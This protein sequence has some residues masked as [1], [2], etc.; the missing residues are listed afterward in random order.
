MGTKCDAEGHLEEISVDIG[1]KKG[2][3]EQKE[4]TLTLESRD[5]IGTQER[6]NQTSLL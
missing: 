2:C 6:T 3:S 4:M 5:D 1:L